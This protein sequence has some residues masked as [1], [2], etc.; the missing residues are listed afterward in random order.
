MKSNLDIPY[1][2]CSGPWFPER[3]EAIKNGFTN[4]FVKLPGDVYRSLSSPKKM[5]TINDIAVSKQAYPKLGVTLFLIA[6]KD[7]GGKG[8]MVEYLSA[9]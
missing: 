9:Y 2:W 7:G 6:P 8:T 3:I 4:V 1:G 5:Y